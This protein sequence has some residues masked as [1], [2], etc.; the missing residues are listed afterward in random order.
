MTVKEL[1]DY[2]SKENPNMEVLVNGY[3]DGYDLIGHIHHKFVKPHSDP[4]WYYG[5]FEE[6]TG[7]DSRVALIIS[8]H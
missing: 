5:K 4:A 1:I 6:G 3:E 7:K 2:L 8:R